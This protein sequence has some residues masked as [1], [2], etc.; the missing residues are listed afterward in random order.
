MAKTTKSELPE[1][2]PAVCVDH[3]RDNYH[4]E[5]ELPGV[6]KTDIN[7]EMGEQSFCIRASKKDLIYNACY[8]LAHSVDTEKVDAKFESGL[9]TITAP[10]KSPIGGVKI[11]IT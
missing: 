1:V 10:F 5:I 7:L 4:I 8:T 11:E 2:S 3:S 6:K 9:L